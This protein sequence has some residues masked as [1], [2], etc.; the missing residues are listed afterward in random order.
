VNLIADFRIFVIWKFG[1]I[2]MFSIPFEIDVE[3][4][5]KDFQ[6]EQCILIVGALLPGGINKIPR[7]A[8]L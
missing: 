5:P 4:V 6:M 3:S 1:S 2:K 7:V 8:T